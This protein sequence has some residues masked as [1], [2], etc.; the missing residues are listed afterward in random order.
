MN[1]NQQKI[2]LGQKV[3]WMRGATFPNV[4][5]SNQSA[6]NSAAAMSIPTGQLENVK[7]L[8]KRKSIQQDQQHVKKP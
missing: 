2:K 1:K 7:P 4:D 5:N 3:D 6:K 8:P